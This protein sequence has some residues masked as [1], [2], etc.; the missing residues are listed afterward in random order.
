[1]TIDQL[2]AE[3]QRLK[4]EEVTGSTEV[5]IETE[6]LLVRELSGLSCKTIMSLEKSE[7]QGVILRGLQ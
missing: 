5:F 2:I 7:Y 3:L 1:M 6:S 4:E